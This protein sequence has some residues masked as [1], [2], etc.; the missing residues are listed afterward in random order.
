MNVNQS[1]L[2]LQYKQETGKSLPD[3]QE[4]EVDGTIEYP[5]MDVLEQMQDIAA[6]QNLHDQVEELEVTLYKDFP[7]Y[8]KQEIQ[9]HFTMQFPI[10]QTLSN[11]IEWLESKIIL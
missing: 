1:E 4:F 8:L 6:C 9:I 2:Q 7:D 5:I 11:Y 3:V 10:E